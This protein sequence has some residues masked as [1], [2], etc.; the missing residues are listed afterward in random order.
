MGYGGCSVRPTHKSALTAATQATAAPSP[1]SSSRGTRGLPRPVAGGFSAASTSAAG[2]AAPP[3]CPDIGSAPTP[4]IQRTRQV[5]QSRH[6]RANH[7]P[8]DVAASCEADCWRQIQGP[9]PTALLSGPTDQTG[10]GAPHGR[11]ADWIGLSDPGVRSPVRSPRRRYGRFCIPLLRR[12]GPPT[13]RPAAS[14]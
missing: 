14:G 6:S 13:G 1:A 4:V 9:T 7:E 3:A 8:G 10:P 5:L 12:H 11:P 2:S